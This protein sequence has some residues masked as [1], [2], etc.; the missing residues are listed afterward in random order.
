MNKEKTSSTQNLL[1]PLKLSG[2]VFV[3]T[4][5]LLLVFVWQMPNEIPLFFSRSFGKKQLVS[6]FVLGIL[7]LIQLLVLG[8][9]FLVKKYCKQSKVT[10]SLYFW[11][12]FSSVVLM[13]VSMLYVLYLVF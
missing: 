8:S 7:P 10:L 9:C 1:L 5:I 2:F 4:L 3:V 6:P 11:I 13:L 12:S